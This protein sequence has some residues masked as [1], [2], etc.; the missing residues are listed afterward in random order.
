MSTIQMMGVLS[1]SGRGRLTVIEINTHHF[2]GIVIKNDSE[3]KQRT[4]RQR[5][6]RRGET[7][8]LAGLQGRYHF[9]WHGEGTG[10]ARLPAHAQPR[11]LTV[12]FGKP[13]LMTWPLAQRKV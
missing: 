5:G 11:E 7:G 13:L 1:M 12:S 9:C 3:N 8:G 2:F 6:R 4:H 10:P